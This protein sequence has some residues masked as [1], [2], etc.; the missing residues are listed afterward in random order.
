MLVQETKG[1]LVIGFRF[2]SQETFYLSTESICI[3]R[4]N[5]PIDPVCKKQVN[6][7]DAAASF[8]YHTETVYFCSLDCE[9]RFERDPD[10]YMHQMGEEDTAA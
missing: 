8:D 7:A 5:M 10:A 2:D 6:I 3:W 1:S 4:S 9:K